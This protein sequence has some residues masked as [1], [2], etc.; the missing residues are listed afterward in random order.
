MAYAS[1]TFADARYFSGP[2]FAIGRSRRATFSPLTVLLAT[3]I[4]TCA[5]GVAAIF[6]AAWMVGAVLSTHPGFHGRTPLAPELTALA[7]PRRI[8]GTAQF[9]GTAPA[10]SPAAYAR[11]MALQAELHRAIT[12][13][14]VMAPPKR[15]IA[16]A[17]NVPPPHPTSRRESLAKTEAAQAPAPTQVARLTPVP[18]PAPAPTEPAPPPHRVAIADNKVPLPPRRPPEAPQ[19]AVLHEVA[20][21]TQAPTA[22]PLVTGSLPPPAA[23]KGPTVRQ[24]LD[25]SISLPGPGSHIAVYDIAAHTVYLPD[26]ERLEAHSGLGHRLDDPRYVDQRRRGPTP[27]NIYDLTLR[28]HLFHGVRAIRLNPVDDDKMYG[29]DGMLAHTYM[30]GPSG[31]SFGCVSFKHYT[32][33]LQAFLNG[34]I[35]RL[36]VVPRLKSEPRM[37]STGGRHSNHYAFNAW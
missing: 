37:A 25:G 14:H 35:D 19:V 20:R 6:A 1:A 27:P 16:R 7:G 3:V 15:V 10:M 18:V 22:A 29:R 28:G 12:A 31:Q 30:L 36:V 26:G 13:A 32:K 11:D 23:P 24:A 17:D 5:M 9:A 33:F 4:G 21:A 34:K 8:A 2:V